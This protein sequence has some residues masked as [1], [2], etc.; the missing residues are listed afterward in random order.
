[1]GDGCRGFVSLNFSV[2]SDWTGYVDGYT[3]SSNRFIGL[4]CGEVLIVIL[5]FLL[6]RAACYNATEGS[7]PEAIEGSKT[8]GLYHSA[9]SDTQ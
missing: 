9:H 3:C 6:F 4:A 5:V 7:K 8:E 2:C 1:M